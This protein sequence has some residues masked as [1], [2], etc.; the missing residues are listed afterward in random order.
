MLF[1]S[2]DA[3]LTGRVGQQWQN[4]FRF[5]G[6]ASNDASFLDDFRLNFARS[7]TQQYVAPVR[8][9]VTYG[10][11]GGPA[12]MPATSGGN[13]D[14]TDS[15]WTIGMYDMHYLNRYQRDSGDAPLGIPALKPS[16]V[17]SSIAHTYKDFDAVV[18]GDGTVA[19]LWARLLQYTWSGPRL[20]GTLGTVAESDRELYD[21]EKTGAAEV[22]IRAGQQEGDASLVNF[23]RQLTIFILADALRQNAP[24]GKLMG[25]DLTRIH[26]AV[27]LLANGNNTPLPQPSAPAAPSA[28][29]AQAASSSAINLSWQDNSS[30]ETSFRVEQL[31]NGAYQEVQ[32]LAAGATT[33]QIT[34]LAASTSYSFRVR[35]GNAVGYSG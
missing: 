8:N 9:G 6:L 10:F 32:A 14:L 30:D 3:T 18:F 21:P 12:L 26:P 4:V 20:G 7:I 34:G 13:T 16:Q 35:A 5:M 2:P 31:V 17:I 24:L 29:T 25:Q 11:W 22:L 33:V 28:L 23:G 1:R 27:A 15:Q 19:G